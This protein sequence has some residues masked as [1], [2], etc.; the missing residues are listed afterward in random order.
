[1]CHRVWKLG[2]G[3]QLHFF[4]AWVTLDES[5]ALWGLGTKY[6]YL[7]RGCEEQRR[8]YKLWGWGIARARLLL[9]IIQHSEHSL[10]AVGHLPRI[11]VDLSPQWAPSDCLAVD[12]P[13]RP[14]P[15]L[16]Q[17]LAVVVILDV[18]CFQEEGKPRAEMPGRGSFV[19]YFIPTLEIS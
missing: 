8:W 4:W 3:S 12:L 14:A 9:F 2:S 18:C 5:F 17:Q 13:P 6:S 7:G 11:P 16:L 1:M 19:T 10:R 15:L